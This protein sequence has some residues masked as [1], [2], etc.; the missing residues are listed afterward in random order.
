MR[1][2]KIRPPSSCY[3]SKD[4]AVPTCGFHRVALVRDRLPKDEMHL[5][6]IGHEGFSYFVC[7]VSQEVIDDES[8]F[9]R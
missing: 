9:K 5:S 2:I 7:P 6:G 4:S 8:H 3:L 1:K